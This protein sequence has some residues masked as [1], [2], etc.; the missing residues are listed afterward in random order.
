MAGATAVVAGLAV[1]GSTAVGTAT[2]I[3]TVVGFGAVARNVARLAALREGVKVRLKILF[4]SI[5]SSDIYAVAGRT[6]AGIV[7]SLRAVARLIR[8]TQSFSARGSV[9]IGKKKE[10]ISITGSLKESC[11]CCLP[12]LAH[13]TLLVAVIATHGKGQK[14]IVSHLG[15]CGPWWNLPNGL[16]LGAVLSLVANYFHIISKKKKKDKDK[17]LWSRRVGIAHLLHAQK[18]EIINSSKEYR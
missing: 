2:A 14:S 5:T 9:L 4:F 12:V 18:R 3:T 10:E 15:R 13:V 8:I 11:V 16:G 7:T 17:R 6:A 1:A